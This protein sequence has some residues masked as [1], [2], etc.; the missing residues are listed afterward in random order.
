MEPN[1]ALPPEAGERSGDLH[2]LLQ[3]LDS[4]FLPLAQL[5]VGKGVPIQAA[6]E[7]LRRAF[8]EAARRSS[9][10]ANP[11]RMTSRISTLTGLTRREVARIEALNEPA[12]P[13][14]RSSVSEVFT[15][16]LSLPEY[17]GAN[18][19]M[20][21]PRVGPA[22]SFET[23]AQSVTRD[24]HARS[25]LEALMQ[26]KLVAWHEESDTVRLSAEAFV[27]R[28][29]WTQMM[30]FLGDNV[31]DHLRAAVTNVMGHGSEHF[32]Q[33]LYADELSVQSLQ[34]ARQIISNQWRTLMTEVVPQLEAL[35]KADA[36]AGRPQ[37]QALRLGLYSWSQPMPPTPETPETAPTEDR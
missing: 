5:C 27:P 1:P 6:E 19:P 2:S 32:E 11:Q 37:D 13:T 28:D 36:M 35:M 10:G 34:Q 26:L 31:G 15:H 20:T 21:L 3:A 7:R 18:G 23:L 33:A 16:W 12:R 17:K 8:V 25:L 29:Q 24:V 9:D 4:L 30:G 22:P 14:S